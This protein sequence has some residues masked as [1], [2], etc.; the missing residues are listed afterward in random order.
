MIKKSEE[1]EKLRASQKINRAVFDAIQPYF[2]MGVS[3]REIARRIQ[4][5]Q[6]ELGGE[7]PSFPPIVAF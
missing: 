5:L 4:I 7:G 6:L 2:Q 3:E 1:I